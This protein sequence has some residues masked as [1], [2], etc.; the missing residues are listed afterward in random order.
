MPQDSTDDEST[1]VRL[2][3]STEPFTWAN[4]DPDQCHHMASLNNSAAL[5]L[6]FFDPVI[7]PNT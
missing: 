4:I 3:D 7:P 5:L 2:P 1:L 6:A